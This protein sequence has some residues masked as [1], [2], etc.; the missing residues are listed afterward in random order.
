M[1][2]RKAEMHYPMG[3]ALLPYSNKLA[4]G[5]TTAQAD[6]HGSMA[7]A[8]LPMPVSPREWVLHIR[9]EEG[10]VSFVKATLGKKL[11]LKQKF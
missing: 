9:L 2:A 8:A 1:T 5:E 7:A 4:T 3:S 11:F 10:E 6:S